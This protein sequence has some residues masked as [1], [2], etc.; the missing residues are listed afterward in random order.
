MPKKKTRRP[1]TQPR[2]P[3]RLAFNDAILLQVIRPRLLNAGHDGVSSIKD[4]H[5]RFQSVHACTVP[6]NTF[7]NWLKHL[8]FYDLFTSPRT[9]SPGQIIPG[10]LPSPD[11]RP[12]PRIPTAD[13][14]GGDDDVSFTRPPEPPAEVAPVD[15]AAIDRMLASR[16]ELAHLAGLGSPP[17]SVDGGAARP[18]TFLPPYDMGVIQ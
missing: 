9:I 16:P 18:V 14:M 7:R 6:Y 13:P 11:L 10:P 17:P 8:G 3:W 1:K 5:T 12:D 4:W 2:N 15:H